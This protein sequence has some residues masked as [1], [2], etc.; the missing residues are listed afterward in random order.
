MEPPNTRVQRTRSSPSAPHSPLTRYPLGRGI[1]CWA[2]A[3]VIAGAPACA[4]SPDVPASSLPHE[5]AVPADATNV[6]ARREGGVAA[7]DYEMTAQYPADQFLA[8]VDGRLKAAGWQAQE[9]D[10]LNPTIRTS[11]A[12][13][14]TAFV[15]ARQTPH[16]AVHQWLGDWR[17]QKGDVV[18]YGLRY[19]TRAADSPNAP[20]VPDNAAL[21]VTA[22]LIPAAQAEQMT[23]RAK[24]LAKR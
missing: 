13:G 3:L 9:M 2:M 19:T 16:I 5:L 10:F 11:N 4:R 15:D 7:V 8:E 12:R 23:A 1:S 14:W 22:F 24:A 17:N 6:K 20:S 18:S 21:H